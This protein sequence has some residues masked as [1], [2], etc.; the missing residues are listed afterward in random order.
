MLALHGWGEAGAELTRLSR[1][2]RWAEMD[3]LVD[4]DML[5]AF[6]IVAPPEEV[7]ALLAQRCA[8][9]VDRVSF[10]PHAPDQALLDAIRSGC[11]AREVPPSVR[12]D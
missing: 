11:G 4:D 8:G 5:R 1:A 3:R 7:P 9:V 10:L 12:K 2:G 6:A